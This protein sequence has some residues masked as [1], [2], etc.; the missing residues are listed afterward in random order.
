MSNPAF[1]G[2][3][4][5]PITILAALDASAERGERLFGQCSSCHSADPGENRAG[6]HLHSV[7]GRTAGSVTG[8]RHSRALVESGIVWDRE[9]IG[10]DV[11][12]PRGA[13]RGTSMTVGL[14]DATEQDI[15][16]LGRF[17]RSRFSDG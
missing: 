11:A 6:P 13:V 14:R 17:L 7:L 4:L 10:N 2:T 1:L 5:A 9:A 3:L 12:N 8:F 16:D 15:D